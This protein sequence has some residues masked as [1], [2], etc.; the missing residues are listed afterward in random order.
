M[1]LLVI[2][3]KNLFFSLCYL[4]YLIPNVHSLSCYSYDCSICYGNIWSTSDG[5]ANQT[6]NSTQ[7][8]CIVKIKYFLGGNIIYSNS[9]FRKRL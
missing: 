5:I 8:S 4:I 2:S 3:S 6:C 7:R 1:R 9:S